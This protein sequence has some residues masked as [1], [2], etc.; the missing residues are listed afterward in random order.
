MKL[1]NTSSIH[2]HTTFCDGKNTPAEMAAAAAAQGLRTL[3]FSG[4]QPLPHANEWSMTEE[5]LPRYRAEVE[6]LRAEWAGRLDILLGLE[7]DWCI[8]PRRP[9]GFDYWIGSTHILRGPANGR[10]YE[11]DE[12]TRQ[13]QACIRD[14][15]EGDTAAM[16]RAY[17]RQVVEVAQMRP[18]VLGHF[19][20]IVKTNRDGCLFDE[21]GE[22]YRAIAGEA[23]DACIELGVCFEMNTGA[24]WRGWRKDAYPADWI[25]RRMAQADARLTLT[26]DAHET[27]ALRFGYERAAARAAAAGVRTLWVC[28][29]QGWQ[30]CAAE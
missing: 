1:Y 16:L 28:T 23:L 5:N 2:T 17:Y 19:D 27:A 6:R 8:G 14:G 4:H 20:L 18:D 24:V 11:V 9:E 30:R 3:G 10:L 22:E 13:M 25:L 26:A 29:A 21:D 12:S 15:F 7:Y